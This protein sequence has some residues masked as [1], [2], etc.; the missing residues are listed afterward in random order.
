MEVQMNVMNPEASEL[1]LSSLENVAGQS[2]PVVTDK[3]EILVI[4][5]RY[6][7]VDANNRERTPAPVTSIPSWLVGQYA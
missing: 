3:G 5:G 6:V 1:M 7:T 2:R 4:D